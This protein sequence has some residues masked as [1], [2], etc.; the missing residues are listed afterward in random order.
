MYVYGVVEPLYYMH[1]VFFSPF[2]YTVQ[3]VSSALFAHL[4]STG[5]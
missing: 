1:N 4:P 3:A 2:D 5:S